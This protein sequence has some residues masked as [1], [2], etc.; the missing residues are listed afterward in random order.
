MELLKKKKIATKAM[1]DSDFMLFL[2]RK[3]NQCKMISFT[4][5]GAYLTTFRTNKGRMSAQ[6]IMAIPVLY[7][8]AGMNDTFAD[9][10]ENFLGQGIT[11]YSEGA[12]LIAI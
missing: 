5:R 12:N 11:V 3:R 1:R 9:Q 10:V 8:E 7:L 2:N 4:A 6:D